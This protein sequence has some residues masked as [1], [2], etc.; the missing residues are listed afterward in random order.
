MTV[1]SLKA[2]ADPTRLHIVQ[3]LAAC[4]CSQA[5]LDDQGDVYSPTAGEVCCHIT[6]L[7][8]INS[9]IS[10]H[11]HELAEAGLIQIERHGKAMRCRLVLGRFAELSEAVSAL[12]R[13]NKSC[14]TSCEVSVQRG[15]PS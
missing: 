8:K 2:L 11:L 5:D 10:H 3:F 12:A 6:G 14:C 4:C 7:D 1:R 13:A 15:T 9:T